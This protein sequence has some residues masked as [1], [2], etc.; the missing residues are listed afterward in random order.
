MSNFVV[1]KELL[2]HVLPSNI[3]AAAVEEVFPDVEPRSIS[4]KERKFLASLCART[5][6]CD[7]NAIQRWFEKQQS[8]QDS[9]VFRAVTNFLSE[10]NLWSPINW[11]TAKGDNEDTFT[12]AL[13]RPL[14]SATFGKFAGSMFRW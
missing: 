8:V 10:P 4:N 6:L 12:D 11:Y 2:V 3:S 7:F 13:L 14:L 9:I 5:S 1:T